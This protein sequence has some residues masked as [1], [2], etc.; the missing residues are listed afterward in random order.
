M[1]TATIFAQQALHISTGF[2]QQ[3]LLGTTGFAQSKRFFKVQQAEFVQFTQDNL[4]CTMQNLFKV[5]QT[6]HSSTGFAQYNMLAKYQNL[7]QQS[8][9]RTVQQTVDSTTGCRPSTSVVIR[10][11]RHIQITEKTHTDRTENIHTHILTKLKS[12]TYILTEVKTH[13]DTYRQN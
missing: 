8:R 11:C 2:A 10:S 1:Q 12:H 13:I 7:A 6:L 4:F 5:Q 9:P 3:R